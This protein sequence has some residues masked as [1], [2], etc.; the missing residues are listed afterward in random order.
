MSKRLPNFAWGGFTDGELAWYRINDEWGGRNIRLSP[1][2]FA[3]RSEAR[4]QFNDVRKVHI[5]EL[6]K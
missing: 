2:I 3:T 1:A 6:R 4:Q 5:A